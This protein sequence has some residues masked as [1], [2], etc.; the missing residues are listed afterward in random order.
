MNL[1]IAT[2]LIAVVLFIA[3][4]PLARSDDKDKDK[5]NARTLTGCLQKG[6]EAKE[7]VLMAKDGSTWDLRSDTVDL[8]RHVGHTVT[9]TGTA[10]TV[11]AK[12][13]EMKE[14]AKEEMHEHGMAKSDTEHGHLKA[15]KLTMVS[16]TCQK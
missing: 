11:H 15:T 16:D 13:H 6:D 1:K 3:A 14:G 10:S 5:D 4:V 8:A 7:Y 2:G 9:I 12:A